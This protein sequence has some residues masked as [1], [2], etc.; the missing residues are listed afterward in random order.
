[1]TG[2]EFV[3]ERFS[4]ADAYLFTVLNWGQ[5]TPVELEKWPALKAYV[6]RL[7]KR[8]SIA[9]ALGEEFVLFTE[10]QQRASA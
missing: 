7:R 10:E 6:S 4:V 8:P 2:R 9:R 1:M 3:L 5:A